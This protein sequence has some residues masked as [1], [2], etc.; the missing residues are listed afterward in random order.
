MQLARFLSTPMTDD[1]WHAVQDL[2]LDALPTRRNGH[3]EVDGSTGSML[4]QHGRDSE[5]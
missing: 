3:G 1:P 4:V 5:E 2:H